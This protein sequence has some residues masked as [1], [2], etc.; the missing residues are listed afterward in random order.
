MPG[1]VLQPGGWGVVV[2]EK[3]NGPGQVEIFNE[4]RGQVRWKIIEK[5][6]YFI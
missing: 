3:K 6:P 5:R 2:G 1:A 4:K